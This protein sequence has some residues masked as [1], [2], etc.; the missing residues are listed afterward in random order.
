VTRLL[1][2]SK[3]TAATSP[4]LDRNPQPGEI[5]LDGIIQSRNFP[6]HGWKYNPPMSEDDDLRDLEDSEL[7]IF[8][9]R[10][11]ESWPLL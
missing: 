4:G 10:R 9:M 7:N 3:V 5:V 8:R 6:R 1:H 11:P 2:T